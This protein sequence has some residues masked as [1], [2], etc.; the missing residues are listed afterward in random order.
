MRPDENDLVERARQGEV[1]AYTELVR[2]HQDQAL[3]AAYVVLGDRHE[4]EDATQEAFTNAYLA[5]GRFRP[6]A[7][8]RAWL[9][10]I[11]INEAHDL[12]AARRR[13]V[14]ALSRAIGAVEI[15]PLAASA[16]AAALSQRRREALLL[17]LF[18]L[19]EADRLVVTCRYF[20]DLSEGEIAEILGVARG[21]VKSRL[22]RALGRLRPILHD[23]GPLVVV[24]PVLDLPHLV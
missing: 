13:R 1:D 20:L 22:S 18:E 23:L 4:A 14:E 24:P 9:L 8:F 15:V 21:T 6:G 17:A 5:L 2:R 3:A 19:P 11:V 7:S 16:E 12:L 10:R